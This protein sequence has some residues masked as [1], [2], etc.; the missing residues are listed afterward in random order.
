VSVKFH[1][2]FWTIFSGA[3]PV[4]ACVSFDSAID[5]LDALS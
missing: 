4:M 5:K 1:N 2:G 3:Q